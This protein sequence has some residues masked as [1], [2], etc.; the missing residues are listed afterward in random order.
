MSDSLHVSRVLQQQRDSEQRNSHERKHNET[1][2]RR[3]P[4]TGTPTVS[5]VIPARNEAKNLEQVLPTLPAVHEV[6]LVDGASSD[7]TVET[8]Q[9]VMPKIRVIHQTRR[10][11]GN[12]LACG[13]SAATGDIIVMFDADGSADPAEIAS[14]VAALTDGAD[15]AKGT[16]FSPGGG[17]EDITRLRQAGNL[18]LNAITNLLFRARYSDLCYGYNA[19][20]RRVLPHLDLPDV[21]LPERPDG[22]MRW[23]DGFEIETILSCRITAAKMI[24]A[25]VPSVERSRIYGASNLNAVT[26][27][28]RVLKSILTE[29]RRARSANAGARFTTRRR[30]AVLRRVSVGRIAEIAER[31]EAA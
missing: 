26:D 10:G 21:R 9:R 29:H 4:G 12:A 3:L 30:P 27:G 19:F 1:E 14:Y 17:S 24:V 31:S 7:G 11:K 15:F 28:L 16:R 22:K 25:E 13:F 8:A 6:I 5:I 23:G 18:A 20:W 2:I